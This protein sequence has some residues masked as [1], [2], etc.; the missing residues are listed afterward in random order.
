MSLRLHQVI[1]LH[2]LMFQ[3]LQQ[4]FSNISLI[5]TTEIAIKK[6]HLRLCAPLGCSAV[7][8]FCNKNRKNQK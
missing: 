4:K 2:V 7:T 3:Y 5:K 8:F 1:K 6:K